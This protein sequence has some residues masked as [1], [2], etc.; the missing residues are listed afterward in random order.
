MFQQTEIH[1][2]IDSST[3]EILFNMHIGYIYPLIWRWY[4]TVNKM[5]VNNVHVTNVLPSS[6]NIFKAEGSMKS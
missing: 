4:I 2:K 1:S 3:I 5:E 6:P